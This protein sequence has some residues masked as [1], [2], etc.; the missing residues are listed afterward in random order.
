MASIGKIN[1]FDTQ[2]NWATYIEC[3][4]QYC[5]ANDIA[6]NKRVPALLSLIGPKTYSLLRDAPLK[7]SSKTFT[8]IVEI[9][10]NHLSPKPLIAERF[11]FHTRD[12][13]EGEGV[14]TYVAVLKKLS[15]HCQ[16]GENVNDTLRDRFVCGLKHE[17]IQKHLLTA[18][19]LTFAKAVEIAVAMEIATKDAFE[20][21]SKRSTDLSQISL[22][23]FTQSTAPP[24][25][26]K[27]QQV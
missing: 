1:A 27:M 4:E 22:H 10:Q 12:Q 20:L 6:D 8:E 26:R 14:S 23:K 17:H 15:E 11:R 16:F 7:P 2:D 24:C 21:Q 19:E 3:L 25:G 13:N 9:L 5:I 18:S